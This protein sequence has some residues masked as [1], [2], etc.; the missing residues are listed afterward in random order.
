M[1]C[2][3]VATADEP[4]VGVDGGVICRGFG[5]ASI[6]CGEAAAARD[7]SH[8]EPNSQMIGP[9]VHLGLARVELSQ[10]ARTP[11]DPLP[12]RPI[13]E[14]G[15]GGDSDITVSEVELLFGVFAGVAFLVF[16]IAV[17]GEVL[18]TNGVPER[19][20]L[21]V[22][23]PVNDHGLFPHH[24][25]VKTIGRLEGVERTVVVAAEGLESLI[26]LAPG[27]CVDH[28]CEV[29][30]RP[31]ERDF[32]AAEQVVS[33]VERF[34]GAEIDFAVGIEGEDDVVVFPS[35]T[36][37][38]SEVRPFPVDAVAARHHACGGVVGTLDLGV[39]DQVR[40]PVIEEELA[41]VLQHGSVSAVVPFPGLVQGDRVVLSNWMMQPQSQCSGL[42]GNQ[43]F[44][45][46]RFEPRADVDGLL[47]HYGVGDG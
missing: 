43:V 27:I 36:F 2:A 15:G 18:L 35:G 26:G 3:S 44:I 42:F 38:E 32:L 41:F 31:G 28:W 11:V 39:E 40:A 47:G 29:V 37:H 21:R 30:G 25:P 46:Q 24:R 16:E 19:Q 17:V 13:D 22:H 9:G 33:V 34:A 1:E 5:D 8:G 6:E 12:F 23:H 14:I 10:P 20:V 4:R 7:I 45:D